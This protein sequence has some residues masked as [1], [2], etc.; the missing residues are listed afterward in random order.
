M[1]RLLIILIV[2]FIFAI[3]LGLPAMLLLWLVGLISP[4]AQADWA[5]SY[6]RVLT[7]IV[8]FL[9]GVRLTVYGKE[10]IPQKGACLFVGNHRSFYDIFIQLQLIRRT[11]GI[12]SKM[13]WGKFPIL[14]VFMKFIHCTFLDRKSLRSGLAVNKKVEEELRAGNAYWIYPEGTRGHLNG[15]LPFHE[16]SFRSAFSTESPIVPV[17]FVH[18]DDIFEKHLPFVKATDVTVVFGKPV[19]TKGL[20]RQEHKAVS[21]AVREEIE[22]T[23]FQYA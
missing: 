10:N 19:P 16:G 11:C 5:L 17:T 1:L 12:V 22:K 3:P 18:T 23:Y 15:L 7:A 20:S 13:E 4:A 9:S 8:I 2:I 6:L 21:A 14:N